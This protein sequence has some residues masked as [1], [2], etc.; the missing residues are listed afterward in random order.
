MALG[1]L[2]SARDLLKSLHNCSTLSEDA[3][4]KTRLAWA[5]EADKATPPN[6]K[7]RT[8]QLALQSMM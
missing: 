4:D 3:T 6:V 8:E 1:A 2:L 5:K 7:P